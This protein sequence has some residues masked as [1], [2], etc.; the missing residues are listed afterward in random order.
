MVCLCE[1]MASEASVMLSSYVCIS[2]VAAAT[3][4]FTIIFSVVAVI[5]V[6]DFMLC[7]ESS[8]VFMTKLCHQQT[9]RP[10]PDM[11]PISLLPDSCF[12]DYHGDIRQPCLTPCSTTN[13]SDNH[14]LPSH[15][16]ASLAWLLAVNPDTSPH[17][18]SP[19]LP[20]SHPYIPCRV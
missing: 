5:I 10:V 9:A 18:I 20:T 17:T 7:L 8:S 13:H 3:I 19:R 1:Q 2:A 12:S 14:C 4:I 15:I 11:Y 6:V 16:H